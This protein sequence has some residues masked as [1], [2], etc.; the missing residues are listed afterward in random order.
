MQTAIFKL[1]YVNC[2]IQFHIKFEIG[3]LL[4]ASTQILF[5]V[6]DSVSDSIP[7]WVSDS[8]SISS[9]L[10][11]ADWMCKLQYANCNMQT[12]ICKLQYAN[13][14]MQTA[15]CKL[16][17]ANCNMLNCNMQTA[18]CKPQN[19]NCNKQTVICKLQSANFNLQTTTRKQQS[20]ICKLQ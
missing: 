9:K 6:P 1:K 2:Q 10:L 3:F 20:A 13:C 5:W 17:Y 4:L 12:E 15:I 18:I 7:H 19:A 16:Q 8:N 14:N 11:Y